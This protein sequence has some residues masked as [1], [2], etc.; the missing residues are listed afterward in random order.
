MLILIS[1]TW[2]ISLFLALLPFSHQLQRVFTNRA[3][4]RDNLFFRNVI[5]GFE[6]ARRWAESIITFSPE[7]QSATSATVANI[8]SANSWSDLQSAL[9]NVSYANMLETQTFFG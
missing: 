7:L 1:F 5:V 4:I 9:G 2:A 6:A 8:R 3:I